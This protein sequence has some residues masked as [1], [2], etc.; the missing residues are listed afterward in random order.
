MKKNGTLIMLLAVFILTAAFGKTA[1]A[2][3]VEPAPHDHIWVQTDVAMRPTC[4]SPAYYV[5]RCQICGKE[6]THITEPAL[7]HDWGKWELAKAGDCKSKAVEERVCRRCHKTETRTTTYGGHSWGAWSL[8]KPATC[9]EVGKEGRVCSVCK[10]T[11]MRDIK[12]LGHNWGAWKEW[13]KPSCFAE[14]EERRQCSRCNMEESRPIAKTE[15]KWGAWYVTAAPA[16]GKPGTEERRCSV[17]MTT[18]TREIAAGTPAAKIGDSG[19]LVV[20]AQELLKEGGEYSGVCD[21]IFRE[22]LA[23]AIKTYEKEA[24]LP[25]TGTI[26]QDTLELLSGRFLNELDLEI[27]SA[28]CTIYIFQ[29][30]GLHVDALRECKYTSNGDGTHKVEPVI[31]GFDYNNWKDEQAEIFFPEGAEVEQNAYNSPCHMDGGGSVCMDCG[32][33]MEKWKTESVKLNLD[34]LL[35]ALDKAGDGIVITYDIRPG[36]LTHYDLPL[37]EGLHYDTYWAPCLKWD[38]F[39]DALRYDVYVWKENDASE[40]LLIEDCID[41]ATGYD[42]SKLE[43]G[44]YL[45]AVLAK[46]DSGA[47]SD[48]TFLYFNVAGDTMPEPLEVVLQDGCASWAYEYGNLSPIFHVDL[49]RTYV[50]DHGLNHESVYEADTQNAFMDFTEVYAELAVKGQIEPG[51]SLFVGVM[52][53]DAEGK[54]K[55]SAMVHSEFVQWAVPN[56]YRVL[57]A[58]NVRRGPGKSFERIGGYS[59]GDYF[60]S[61][62]TETGTDGTYYVVNY[63]GQ[64][65]YVLSSCAAWF[66][67]KLF[68]SHVDMGDG[69]SA[70]VFT[71]PDG[72]IDQ[73][74][75]A[76]KVQKIGWRLAALKQTAGEGKGS[77]LNFN[78]VLQLG[79]TF[80]A[81]WEK[82]PDYVF[83]RFCDAQGGAIPVY[84]QEGKVT[85]EAIPIRI[86]TTFSARPAD[87]GFVAGWRCFFDGEYTEVTDRTPFTEKM[88]TVTYYE[89]RDLEITI[90]KQSLSGKPEAMLNLYD[91]NN[92]KIGRIEAG[93]VLTILD[94]DKRGISEKPMVKVHVSRLDQDGYVYES[95]L[96]GPNVVVTWE[97]RF[98]ANG[99]QCPVA[100]LRARQQAGYAY[101][102]LTQLPVTTRNGYYFAGW[103]DESGKPVRAGH[104]F[105]K[106]VTLTANWIQY[107]GQEVKQGLTISLGAVP[108]E[109]QTKPYGFET[110]GSAKQIPLP[111]CEEVQ[112]IG[113][114]REMYQCLRSD[115]TIVWVE[116]RFIETDFEVI[117]STARIG[118]WE[119]SLEGGD[120]D[121]KYMDDDAVYALLGDVSYKGQWGTLFYVIGRR[122]ENWQKVAV[123]NAIT[124]K[125]V[126]LG[127]G[128]GWV[129][130]PWMAQKTYCRVNFCAGEGV[131]WLDQTDV[132][133]GQ[134]IPASQFPIPCLSGYEFEG[135]YTDPVL[136]EWVSTATPITKSMTL[137]AHY[138]D[139]YDDYRAATEDAPIYDRTSTSKGKILGYVNAGETVIVQKESKEHKFAWVTHGGVSGWVQ[140]RY[141]KSGEI[142]EARGDRK[143]DMAIRSKPQYKKGTV[144]R[145]VEQTELILVF[146]TRENESYYWVAYP[147]SDGF[148]YVAKDQMQKR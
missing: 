141:L 94:R 54:L 133:L 61:F 34:A 145:K 122:G 52:A 39:P 77:E 45:A 118:R 114:T 15:H 99:G 100:S 29:D 110:P 51:D 95:L 119:F 125:N 138:K 23:A 91:E 89:K 108:F 79:D 24:D 2:N 116:K 83:A 41:G 98:N 128:V 25:E 96:S 127:A 7:G 43:A 57:C 120:P 142:M 123:P 60:V 12:A 11:E 70:E 137:Y 66:A 48:H 117:F 62:G 93:D 59:Q 36:D 136:G 78:K 32:A 143:E 111:V 67:P 71:N 124:S 68:T 76:D 84:D 131:T 9:T 102:T 80:E 18:E 140:T 31:I 106:S 65:G 85:K 20:I 53:M 33:D 88:T 58:V 105:T 38:P 13:T 74:D 109:D 97:V 56:F 126:S 130:N 82:D 69:R 92:K 90:G 144:Y 139:L 113:Q 115:H 75:L 47:L 44:K 72:T 129:C 49:I 14:G 8:W 81:V 132:P 121:D 104:E 21:G 40:E 107:T 50:I 73:N 46:D 103:M 147:C 55:D 6:E 148:A 35:A 3:G 1:E 30:S 17:C 16:H 26:Y 19:I 64:T 5:I 135:W 63:K 42:L 37:V 112:V 10:A 4:T 22:D 146:G 101:P 87:Y 134:T 27:P 28:E 86:G